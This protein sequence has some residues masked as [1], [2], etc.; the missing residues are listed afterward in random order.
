M[1]IFF[2]N[3]SANYRCT[4]WLKS[5]QKKHVHD[6]AS[7]ARHESTTDDGADEDIYEKTEGVFYRIANLYFA[8][9]HHRIPIPQSIERMGDFADF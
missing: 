3:L 5:Q 7:L 2:L 6:T 8:G 9:K 1:Y 4:E